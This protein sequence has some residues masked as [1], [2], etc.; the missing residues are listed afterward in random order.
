MTDDIKYPAGIT[1]SD[2]IAHD[3]RM[4]RFPKQSDI[5]TFLAER[6]AE[7][8]RTK[9]FLDRQSGDIVFT[10]DGAAG[11][12]RSGG[13]GVSEICPWGVHRIDHIY[14]ADALAGLPDGRWVKAVG[15]PYPSNLFESVRAAWWVLTGRAH[16]IIWP[17]AGDLEAAI[18]AASK[19]A[20]AREHT[21][22]ETR[23]GRTRGSGY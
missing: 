6:T 13:G 18:Y 5:A 16:A 19:P 7:A 21:E 20:A 23:Q 9:Q 1:G 17:E 8:M 22:Y 10:E 12:D 4:G 3:M 2:H 11:P 14:S 15:V